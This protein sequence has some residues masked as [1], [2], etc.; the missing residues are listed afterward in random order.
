M[1]AR[2]TIHVNILSEA[3][4]LAFSQPSS[5]TLGN[6]KAPDGVFAGVEVWG[7]YTHTEREREREIYRERERDIERER[8]REG[9]RERGGGIS[10]FHI[11]HAN[12]SWRTCEGRC[13][14]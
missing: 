12:P 14:W 3:H 6:T 2:F 7:E 1:P 10:I 5:S 13:T 11:Q 4:S 8:E 9:E